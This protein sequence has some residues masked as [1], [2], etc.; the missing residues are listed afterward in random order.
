MI[1]K[2]NA[3]AAI[4]ILTMTLVKDLDLENA[5]RLAMKCGKF[6]RNDNESLSTRLYLNYIINAPNLAIIVGS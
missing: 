6:I 4:A 3:I 5:I 1:D 2:L